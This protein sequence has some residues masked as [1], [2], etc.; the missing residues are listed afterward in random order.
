[1]DILKTNIEILHTVANTL[2][3]KETLNKEEFEGLSVGMASYTQ[4]GKA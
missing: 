2:L 3:E 4:L 1:M